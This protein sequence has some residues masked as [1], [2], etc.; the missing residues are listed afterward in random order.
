M[1]VPVPNTQIA[2]PKPQRRFGGITT[3]RIGDQLWGFDFTG[4]YL[5]ERHVGSCGRCSP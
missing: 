5:T 3:L 1:R 4:V 2:T